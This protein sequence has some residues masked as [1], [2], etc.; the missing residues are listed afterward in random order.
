M[1]GGVPENQQKTY[2]IEDWLIPDPNSTSD[3]T[4]HWNISCNSKWNYTKNLTLKQTQH[5]L[6]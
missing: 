5:S 2:T 1:V 6:V 3:K 4:C